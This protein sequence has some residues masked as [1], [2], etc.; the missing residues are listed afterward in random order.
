MILLFGGTRS[1]TKKKL[2]M[3]LCHAKIDE[4]E[5]KNRKQSIGI[6]QKVCKAEKGM[7]SKR[8]I[9]KIDV[10]KI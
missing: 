3:P 2:I 6:L 5:R 8:S 7:P 1:N 9:F 4:I 10:E